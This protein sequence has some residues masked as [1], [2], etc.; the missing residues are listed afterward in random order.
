MR[1]FSNKVKFPD[2]GVYNPGITYWGRERERMPFLKYV[3]KWRVSWVTVIPKGRLMDQISDFFLRPFQKWSSFLWNHKGLL[4]LSKGSM[5]IWDHPKSALNKNL[6][7]ECLLFTKH[8]TFNLSNFHNNPNR[9]Y[10]PII[11]EETDTQDIVL[12]IK[13]QLIHGSTRTPDT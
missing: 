11:N 1:Y 4:I 5:L 10:M 2:R 9:Y 3:K 7:F 6:I 8:H 12:C 13:L